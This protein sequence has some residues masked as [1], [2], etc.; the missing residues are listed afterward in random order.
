MLRVLF[1][2]LLVVFSSQAGVIYDFTGTGRSGEAVAFQITVS[3]FLDP[4]PV[5]GFSCYQLDTSLNCADDQQLSVFFSTSTYGAGNGFVDAIQFQSS[6]NSGYWFYFPAGSF[7]TAGSWEARSASPFNPGV[8]IV[9]PTT[10][11]EPGTMLL[12]FCGLLATVWQVRRRT[13]A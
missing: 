2:F 3:D 1:V 13:S 7:T 12:A 10:T 9:A 8:L 4:A 5:V 11:P 6:S